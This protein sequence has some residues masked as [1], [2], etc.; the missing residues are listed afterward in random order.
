MLGT[1]TVPCCTEPDR[2]TRICWG[3]EPELDGDFTFNVG[4]LSVEGAVVAAAP[5]EPTQTHPTPRQRDGRRGKAWGTPFKTREHR[6]LR[7]TFSLRFNLK[8]GVA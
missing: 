5:Y 4:L 2:I 7:N 3:P 6:S 1:P 8:C